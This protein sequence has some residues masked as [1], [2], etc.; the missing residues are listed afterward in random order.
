MNENRAQLASAVYRL[1]DLGRIRCSCC[2]DLLKT[3]KV[4]LEAESQRRREAP[5]PRLAPG[6]LPAV[7]Q[8]TQRTDQSSM[9]GIVQPLRAG[10]ADRCNGVD[11]FL[12]Q[13]RRD[14][15]LEIRPLQLAGEQLDHV[16]ER[17]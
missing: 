7:L 12:E 1:T 2:A 17:R 4:V 8:Q 14:D 9:M 16:R 13:S 15:G 6:M 5:D 11:A 10:G 3:V